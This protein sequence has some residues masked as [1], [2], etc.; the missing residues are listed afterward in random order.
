[1]VRVQK[2]D[3]IV[4]RLVLVEL[5]VVPKLRRIHRDQVISSQKT[6]GLRVGLLMNSTTHCSSKE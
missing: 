6:T 5:K 2:L 1:M 3:L 4:G